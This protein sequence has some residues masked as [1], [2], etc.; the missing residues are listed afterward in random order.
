MFNTQQSSNNLF[1]QPIQYSNNRY[2]YNN[3]KIFY[4]NKFNFSDNTEQ[5]IDFNK[6]LY[7]V[8]ITY[9]V[10]DI[11]DN[12]ILFEDNDKIKLIINI[13]F[14]SGN[15]DKKLF[16]NKNYK[17][18]ENVGIIGIS[19]SVYLVTRTGNNIDL[20]LQGIW[21]IKTFN[22]TDYQ[23][24]IYDKDTQYKVEQNGQDVIITSFDDI[25]T[26]FTAGTL[27]ISE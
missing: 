17:S 5:Y 27:K 24:F 26:N 10:I 25:I 9:D 11:D 19:I 13:P 2:N 14:A 4:L 23:F 6:V 12:S 1:I 22:G 20:D 7:T 21:P 15:N 3:S 8:S 16:G 18:K